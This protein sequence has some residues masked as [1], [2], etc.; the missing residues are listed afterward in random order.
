MT[1]VDWQLA[2]RIASA[3]AG[4][5]PAAMP[6]RDLAPVAASAEEAVLAYTGLSPAEPLPAAEWV[7]RREWAAINLTSMAELIGPAEERIGASLP[8]RGRA[9][10]SGLAGRLL[11]VEIGALLGFAAKRVLGQYE[12]SPRHPERPARLLFVGPNVA[13]AAKQL[14]GDPGDVL[15]WVALHETTHAAHFSAAPWL[16]G[17]VGSLVD[18]LLAGT[19]VGISGREMLDRARGLL[20]SDPR[21]TLARLRDSDP[22]SMLAPPA[23][24]ATIAEVQAT[25][26]AIEGYAEHVMDAAG[27]G[28]GDVVE[29]LRVAM[30]HRRRNRSPLIRLVSWLLGFELKLRQYRE[31]KAWADAVA[32]E[33]GIATLNEAWRERSTLPS[34]AEIKAPEAWIARIAAPVTAE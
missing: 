8:E 13:S 28:L 23:A 33:A 20:T 3:A 29:E 2:E 6:G 1:L 22:V 25:M 12:F 18:E 5:G 9:F 26:A 19:S 30:E 14:R 24:Q 16:R 27:G 11:A 31:G 10:A 21:A 34:Q 7:S 17:H 15:A 4:D 32:T